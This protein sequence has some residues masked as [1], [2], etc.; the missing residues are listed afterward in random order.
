VDHLANVIRVEPDCK[1][2]LQRL[3]LDDPD[4]IRNDDELADER[5][6]NHAHDP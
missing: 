6:E 1:A 4:A 5:I 2:P 3:D